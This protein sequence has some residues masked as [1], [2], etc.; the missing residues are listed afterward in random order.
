[1]PAKTKWEPDFTPILLPG[2]D[3]EVCL[4]SPDLCPYLAVTGPIAYPLECIR[5][6]L[7][8][9]QGFHLPQW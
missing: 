5:G 1:M 8:E 6:G 7:G 4:R 2:D 9:G 3:R